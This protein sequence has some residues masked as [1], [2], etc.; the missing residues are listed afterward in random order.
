VTATRFASLRP[1]RH[2]QFL[3]VWSAAL[4]SNVGTWMQTIAVG[5]LVTELTGRASG[6]GFVAA[7]G[8][9]PI[10]ILSP[11]GGALADRVDRRRFLL[12][13][14]I[15]EAFFATLL[16]VIFAPGHADELTVSLAVFGGGCM[17]ALGFPCY[18]AMLPDL[19]GTEDLLGAVSLSSAQFNLGRVIGPALAGL[20]IHLGSYSWAFAVNAGSFFAT[21]LALLAVR[22]PP[23]PGTA[24]ASL[25]QRITDGARTARNEPGCWTA[26]NLAFVMALCASPFIALIPAVAVVLFH[27]D[28]GTTSVLVTAQGI[29][30]VI[31]ALALAPLAERYGRRQ[32][33]VANLFLLPAAL[34][35]YAAAPSLWT[36]A[37]GLV[38][39]G[40]TYISVFSGMNVVIQLQ[41]PAEYRARVLSLYFVVVGVVY[42][43]GAAL[44]G[45]IADLH[46]LR[47][48]TAGGA[49]AMALVVG[50]VAV[51]RPARLRSLDDT[52]A[53]QAL[54]GG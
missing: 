13:T 46:G 19:V 43:V 48:T 51:A 30:A 9:L 26:L 28:A 39:V 38:L 42:P 32:M 10:G 7:A 5:T 1:L 41:A 16:A 47:L 21:V 24:G 11:I 17:A 40:A 22:V 31:G 53:S 52:H 37:F 45:R 29:G 2:R 49:L 27:G 23:P 33:L 4:V 50:L 12:L 54:D 18:Q 3:L 44:Q 20:V 36:A 8:F 14:T 35:V 34:V 15:G 25:W 6:A